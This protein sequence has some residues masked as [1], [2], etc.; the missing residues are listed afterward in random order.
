MDS[1][2]IRIIVVTL[3]TF[4]TIYFYALFTAYQHHTNKKNY[5]TCL[6]I[7]YKYIIM[8]QII[9]NE[10]IYIAEKC[11]QNFMYSKSQH[12]LMNTFMLRIE[13]K[14]GLNAFKLHVQ[15]V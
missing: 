13:Y 3:N 5:I 12:M 4:I 8:S 14:R 1:H 9:I 2:I 6:A 10:L 15:H 11:I 7:R